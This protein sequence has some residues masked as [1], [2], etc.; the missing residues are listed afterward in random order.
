[1]FSTED[2]HEEERRV[3]APPEHHDG[4]F[5]GFW[6]CSILGW[7]HS[8]HTHKRTRTRR[9]LNTTNTHTHTPPFC[10][11]LSPYKRNTRNEHQSHRRVHS[12][13]GLS[14][15]P[16]RHAA[17]IFYTKHTKKIKIPHHTPFTIHHTPYKKPHTPCNNTPYPK[18]IITIYTMHKPGIGRPAQWSRSSRLKIYVFSTKILKCIFLNEC[19]PKF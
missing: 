4:P 10:M 12:A 19:A 9:T 1:M 14:E 6:C 18:H 3:R 8:T 15:R 7:V 11:Y 5:I 16:S 13:R 17:F 2:G